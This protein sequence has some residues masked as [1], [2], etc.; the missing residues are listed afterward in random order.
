M[1]KRARNKT[2]LLRII[3]TV[4]IMIAA[5]IAIT[6]ILQI[7]SANNSASQVEAVMDVMSGA[8]RT[9]DGLASITAAAAQSSIVRAA[10]FVLF[11]LIIVRVALYDLVTG[12][13]RLLKKYF[14]GEKE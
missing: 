2:K 4:G 10:L 7:T 3:V 14:T 9:T 6:I 11:I 5:Y 13:F 12:S 8:K 1:S